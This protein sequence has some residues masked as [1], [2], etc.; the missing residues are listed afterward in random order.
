MNSPKNPA[1]R[2]RILLVED[3]P[4]IAVAMESTLRELGFE[5]VATATRIASAL[6]AVSRETID[7]AILDVRLGSQRI[8][9]VADALAA[10]GCPFFF[11]TGYGNPDVPSRHA[12]RA[13]LQKPF[14]IDQLLEALQTEFGLASRFEAGSSGQR[15]RL[16]K[17]HPS[18]AIPASGPGL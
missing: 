14:R 9:P 11:M 10:R 16:A 18:S 6:E 15:D 17:P 3:E 7:C 4:L 2:K 12:A 8:D 1:P 5:V 13:V